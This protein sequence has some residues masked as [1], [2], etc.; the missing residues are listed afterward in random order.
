MNKCPFRRGNIG[1]GARNFQKREK[2][3][4]AKNNGVLYRDKGMRYGAVT[5]TMHFLLVS[6][7]DGVMGV[8]TV[9]GGD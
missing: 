6:T 9:I 3:R 7:I 8:K 4:L 2:R 5:G 1:G